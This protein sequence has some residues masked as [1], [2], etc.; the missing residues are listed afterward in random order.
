MRFG[1]ELVDVAPDVTG[2]GFRAFDAAVDEGG[3]VKAVVAPGVAGYSRREVSALQ[4]IVQGA[5]AAGMATIALNDDGS[6]RS[7]L[8]RFFDEGALRAAAGNAGA[9]QG[10]LVCIVAGSP[11]IVAEALGALR[12][13]LGHALDLI[14]PNQLAFIWIIDFPLFEIDKENGGFT[15]SH[16]PFCSPAD[17]SFDLLYSDPG[18][19]LSKQYDLIGN[20]HEIGGGSI[21]AHRAKDLRRIYQVMGYSEPEI[22]DSIGHMLEAF[23]Y[24]APPHGGIAMGVDRLAML[25]G[26]TE[27]LRDVTV[28]PK[29][30]AGFDLTLGAP[31]P[32][33]PEQLA[34][35]HLMVRDDQEES[36][37][38]D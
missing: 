33:L 20:G 15:F 16:N 12:L 34:E 36:P 11:E 5:G 23:T 24:G 8:G 38:A 7:P 25:L 3:Q 2:R 37:P 17:D 18:R 6:I 22:D 28:F 35:L 29:N 1:L 10:D 27:N 31:G 4:D 32:L 14:Q 26:G 30:Q 9:S 13:H 21:R 19:A